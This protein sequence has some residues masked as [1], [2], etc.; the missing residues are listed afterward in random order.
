MSRIELNILALLASSFVLTGCDVARSSEVVC[1]CAVRPNDKASPWSPADHAPS[2]YVRSEVRIFFEPDDGDM[3]S[4][5]DFDAANIH[6]YRDDAGESLA[7][8]VYEGTN[9]VSVMFRLSA[10]SQETSPID[11]RTMGVP[12]GP[13]LEFWETCGD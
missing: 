2:N 7:C 13:N 9:H 11:I 4:Q 8:I 1:D 6:W 5:A 10:D 12:F 3:H